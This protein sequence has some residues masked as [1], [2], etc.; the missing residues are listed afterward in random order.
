MPD[1]I[2]PETQS[3][4]TVSEA[5]GKEMT[6]TIAIVDEGLLDITN[7][8]T[9]DPHE[10]FYAREALGVKTWDLFDYVIG[11]FGGGLERILSIG[12]D[13]T[14]ANKNVSVNRFKPVVKF[15]G[16]F[17]LGCGEKQTT[18]FTLPQYV[19]R[20]KPWLLPGTMALMV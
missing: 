14:W 11:A 19:V 15:L 7:Y 3:A 16:P 8:K 10:A 18:K 2:R 5:S 6:Y 1:K 20:L 4:I 9:S 12:G 13:G 17:H